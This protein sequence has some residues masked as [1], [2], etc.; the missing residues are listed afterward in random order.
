MAIWRL[1]S[2]IGASERRLDETVIAW[3][4]WPEDS[5]LTG[6][7]DAL[8]DSL[9]ISSHGYP[10]YRPNSPKMGIALACSSRF[11]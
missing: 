8:H 6:L 1:L 11:L 9:L 4:I 3:I 2:P 5:G 10:F 7:H